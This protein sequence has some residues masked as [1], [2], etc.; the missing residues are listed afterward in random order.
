MTDL[1]LNKT[2]MLWEWMK[3]QVFIRTSSIVKWGSE[4]YC[5]TADRIARKF[6]ERGKLRRL[7]DHEKTSLGY[8]TREDIY[9]VIK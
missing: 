7:N 1:F 5:N 4:N 6:R 8:E 9:E 3:P 2:E